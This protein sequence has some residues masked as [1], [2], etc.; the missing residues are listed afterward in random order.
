V[1]WVSTVVAGGWTS[2]H[3]VYAQVPLLVLLA[4]AFAQHDRG[5]LRLGA[6]LGGLTF[7]S[8]IAIWLVPARPDAS[9]E[10]PVAFE[11]A[12]ALAD[13]ET[14]I[15]CSSWGCYYTYSLLNKR[16]IPVVFADNAKMTRRLQDDAKRQDKRIIHLCMACDLSAVED[17]Y[18]KSAVSQVDADTT[19]WYIFRVD[20]SVEPAPLSTMPRR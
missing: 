6:A 18:P 17:L 4:Y 20:P 14:I 2:H 8:L 19:N 16:N 10:I 1:L 13:S 11:T 7:L 5:Y 15:N 12:V 3:F 9:R